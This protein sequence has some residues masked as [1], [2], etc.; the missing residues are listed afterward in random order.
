MNRKC[1]YR[2]SDRIKNHLHKLLE[3]YK[4]RYFLLNGVQEQDGK[5]QRI[6]YVYFYLFLNM[7]N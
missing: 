3:L 1:Y 7:R 2:S 4:T 6:I 5:G